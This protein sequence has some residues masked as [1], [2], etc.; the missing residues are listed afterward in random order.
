MWAHHE[1]LA[2]LIR[3]FQ[4]DQKYGESPVWSCYVRYLNRKLAEMTI[5]KEAPTPE[6]WTAILESFTNTEV[7]IVRYVRY[8]KGKTVTID[9]KVPKPEKET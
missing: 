2:E 9:L 5:V 7:E 1:P 6:V 4:K 3:V 8:R